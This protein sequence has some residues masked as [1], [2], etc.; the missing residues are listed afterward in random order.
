MKLNLCCGGNR[1]DGWSNH[2]MDMDISKA[3]PVANHSCTHVLIE[4]GLEHVTP[5][6]AYMCLEEIHRVLKPGGVARVCIPDIARIWRL[7]SVEYIKVAKCRTN[8]DCVRAAV[9]NHGHAGAW[10]AEL[11]ETVMQAIGF[12]TERC[13]YGESPHVELVGVDGHG[14][15]V[16]ENIARIETSI[17]EGTK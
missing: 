15:V 7:A 9:F 1:L 3:L 2:D 17:I 5:Q 10:T 16:G 11:L 12:T 14:K 13:S 6:L 8:S 4:H